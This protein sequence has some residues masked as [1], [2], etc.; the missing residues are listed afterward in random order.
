MMQQSRGYPGMVNARTRIP[1]R[2]HCSRDSHL[3]RLR[4]LLSPAAGK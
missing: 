3:M 2:K 4:V 1:S